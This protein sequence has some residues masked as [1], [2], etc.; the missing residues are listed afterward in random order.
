MRDMFIMLARK[1]I[2]RNT[3]GMEANRIL[4]REAGNYLIASNEVSRDFANEIPR[5]AIATSQRRD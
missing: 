1:C 3:R 2:A 4:R 5:L